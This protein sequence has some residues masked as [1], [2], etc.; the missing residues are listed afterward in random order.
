V[1]LLRSSQDDLV[2]LAGEAAD[3]LGIPEPSFVEKVGVTVSK[4]S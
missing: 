3:A 2:A 4:G 1:A